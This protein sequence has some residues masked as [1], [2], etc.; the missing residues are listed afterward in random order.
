MRVDALLGGFGLKSNVF[1]TEPE[2][3]LGTI[4]FYRSKRIVEGLKKRF[5]FVGTSDT[6]LQIQGRLAQKILEHI[7]YFSKGT[8]K[9]DDQGVVYLF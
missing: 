9:F 4:I 3:Q 6:A 2:A 1:Q 8:I 5:E 7:S